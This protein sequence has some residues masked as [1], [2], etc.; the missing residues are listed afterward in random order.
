MNTEREIGTQEYRGR[1]KGQRD[2]TMRDRP[3]IGPWAREGRIMSMIYPP[4]GSFSGD[5]VVDPAPAR[6]SR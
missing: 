3:E 2:T 1:A 6:H 5:L 4:Y